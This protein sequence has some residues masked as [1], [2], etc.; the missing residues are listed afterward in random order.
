MQAISDA[1]VSY[2]VRAVAA[3]FNQLVILMGPGLILALLIHL[4]GEAV[5][6]CAVTVLGRQ[7]WLY[8]LKSLGTTIHELG[9][10][11]ACLVFGHKIDRIEL[12]TPD[13][14]AGTLGRV[15]YTLNSRNIYQLIGQFFVG[16]GPILLGTAVIYGSALLLLG[17]QLVV[18]MNSLNIDS[19]V[20]GS[21]R[22]IEALLKDVY[23]ASFSVMAALFRFDNFRHWQFYLF[24]YIAFSVGNS[25]SLSR[26]DIQGAYSGFLTLIV[27]LLVFNLL[28][29]WIGPFADRYLAA[30]SRLYESFYKAMTF[31]L[32][33]NLMALVILLPFYALKR[34][35]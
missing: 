24:L 9:H 22:S 2:C 23:A 31:A 8:G 33:L 21:F 1:F 7:I 30:F 19:S 16:I 13:M 25:M 15:E 6:N 20:F 32:V 34:H 4:V 3:T 35:G 28:T 12:F 10:A 17:P 29:L 11:L 18:S 14:S 26:A 5:Q 27:V